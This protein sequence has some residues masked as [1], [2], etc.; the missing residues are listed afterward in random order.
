MS[1]N[2][3]DTAE[4]AKDPKL[5]HFLAAYAACREVPEGDVD[6]LADRCVLLREHFNDLVD[7]L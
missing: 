4:I 7:D 5:Q 1:T 2:P 3:V 6:E